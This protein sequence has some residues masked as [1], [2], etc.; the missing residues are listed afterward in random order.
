[1]A[2]ALS[3]FLNGLSFCVSI[4]VFLGFFCGTI[5]VLLGQM[6]HGQ[7]PTI[8]DICRLSLMIGAGAAIMG[9]L[10]VILR[11]SAYV[12]TL[13]VVCLLALLIA[14]LLVVLI[15][16]FPVLQPIATIPGF[17]IGLILGKLACLLCRKKKV[18]NG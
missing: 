8:D 7:H 11:Y 18:L 10:I 2:K 9:C 6:A 13:L 5:L 14:W 4:G 3:K 17:L 1:M 15:V 16:A 12:P